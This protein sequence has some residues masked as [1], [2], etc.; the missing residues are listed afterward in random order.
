LTA[1]RSSFEFEVASVDLPG[2]MAKRV[3]GFRIARVIGA[4]GSGR[5]V[6]DG[7]IVLAPAASGSGPED[8]IEAGRCF[9]MPADL[10]LG[11]VSIVPALAH[12]LWIWDAAGLELGELALLA[13][14]ATPESLLARVAFWRC[15]GR[16]MHLQ[17]GGDTDAIRGDLEVLNAS[18]QP[19]ATERLN[20]AIRNA[21]GVAAVICI[22]SPMLM[23]LVLDAVPAWTR[24]VIAAKT[25]EPATV[26]FYNN[27][28]RKGC[29]IIGAPSS[30]AAMAD[31][32]WYTRAAPYFSRAASI[33]QNKSL[34]AQ[35][36]T[37]KP[38]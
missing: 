27:V 34:V 20:E 10:S 23:E 16:V 25:T 36:V 28:H 37:Q 32:A 11:D 8:R 18:E 12:S 33:M 3:E 15:G 31:E 29:R 26:D 19:G 2:D 13:T 6:P 38:A 14:G 5:S 21:P 7:R 24:I 4:F 35:L 30:P 9:A 17:D 22:C 1:V